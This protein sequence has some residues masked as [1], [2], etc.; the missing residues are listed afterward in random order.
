[1]NQRT[2]KELA[3][4]YRFPLPIPGKGLL[5][6][7][8]DLEA[9][10]NIPECSEKAIE[11]LKGDLCLNDTIE[12][13]LKTITWAEN[14]L[15]ATGVIL[16]S[17][18]DINL[19]FDSEKNVKFYGTVNI[20]G[21]IVNI[22]GSR[23]Q[24]IDEIPDDIATDIFD[25]RKNADALTQRI[26]PTI[27]KYNN[28]EIHRKID[29]LLT[30]MTLEEKIGQ[31]YQIP[32]VKGIT[33]PDMEM[34]DPVTL[35]RNG[36]VGSVLGILSP[37]TVYPLQ[38]VAVEQSRLKIPLLFMMDVI[39]GYRTIMPIPL[40]MASSWDP[41]VCE[42]AARIAA[43]ESAVA[44][45]HLTFA[46]MVDICR[47][48]RWGRIMEGAGED[49]Y[50]G[51]C[52][53]TAYVKGFQ[54][55][56]L[57]ARDSIL[58]CV[59]HYCAYGASEA[60]RDYNT[61]DMGDLTLR[62]VYLPPYKA[63]VDAGVACLMSS[64]NI[65]GGIPASGNKTL[66]H[67]VLRTEWGFTGMVIS[68]YNAVVEMI[69]HGYV[70]D[71]KAAA[72]ASLEASLDIE[73]VSQA[74]ITYLPELVKEG[75]LDEQQID[76]A[77][78]RILYYKFAIG[79]FD[80]PYKAMDLQGCERLHLCLAHRQAARDV[81]RR[82][83]VL[84]KNTPPK[85]KS[86]TILP[87]VPENLHQIHKIAVIGP[88]GD[89]HAIIGGWS[90]AGRTS[91]TITLL[92]GL[93]SRITAYNDTHHSD[94]SIIY[95]KGC[96]ISD[97]STAHFDDALKIANE[98]DLIILAMG[99]EQHMSGEAKSRA[100]LTMPGVQET[101]AKQ[102]KALSKPTGLVLFNGRPLEIGWFFHNMDFILEAWF[103]GTE[104]GN[105]IAELLFG[106]YNPAGK[107]P[108]S[109][110]VTVG[111]VPVYYNHY[112]TG[113]PRL[114]PNQAGYCT[115]F[116]DIPNDPLLPFGF[117]LSYTTFEYSNIQLSGTIIRETVPIQANITVTN[118]G[119]YAGEEVVQLYIQD[120]IGSVVRPVKELKG[121]VKIMLQPNEKRVVQFTITVE[122]LKYWNVD[123]KWV[124]EPGSFLIYI[125]PSS[126]EGLQASFRLE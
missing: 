26:I 44:G 74:Y 103:L 25:P 22:R 61:V 93:Q 70:P 34:E 2:A 62:N 88:L 38:K 8:M 89:E 90:G 117:G 13:E 10:L 54:G 16:G 77:V 59:K 11:G 126:I 122:M 4:L 41:T 28:T 7:I 55:S 94:I 29:A 45:V 80:D 40:A 106:D 116:L 83:M 84:L 64:F 23:E 109:F 107:L 21:Q 110:P 43:I 67:D 85:G 92:Q 12:G 49:P 52:V 9:Q 79:L 27:P 100:Y 30:Q 71:M 58:A 57:S 121:F 37:L 114:S 108:V 113:R 5:T 87:F 18:I 56:D 48:P 115:R 60:G 86:T 118:S 19:V 20:Y 31:M 39:H 123:R 15:H 24:E 47:D 65:I 105:A 81:A 95:A 17:N 97:P 46:P 69:G 91:D 104:A 119:R 66:L 51:S 72:K 82:S 124:A 1:M 50:L 33:G 76:A 75:I 6:A 111:Q 63:A 14:R 32:A 68:D 102:I 53:A 42:R 120:I 125:G 112:S 98:A 3:G 78:R 36:H 35:I 99:E 73:M 96:G 101:L